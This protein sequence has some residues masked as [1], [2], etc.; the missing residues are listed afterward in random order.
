M[1]AVDPRIEI[2]HLQCFLEVVRF[3]RVGRAA[4]QLCSE[5][6]SVVVRPE[7]RLLAHRVSPPV[8]RI[9]TV[10][11]DF[12]STF[13]ARSDALWVIAGGVVAVDLAAG[14]VVAPPFDTTLAAG[15]VGV[16]TRADERPAPIVGLFTG[17][18]R[19]LAAGVRAATGSAAGCE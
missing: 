8:R 13:L 7:P 6:T 5:C 4:E 3:G 16:T 9:E 11:S 12:A 14:T 1:A 17:I 15:P 10:S 19:R 2:R 18:P